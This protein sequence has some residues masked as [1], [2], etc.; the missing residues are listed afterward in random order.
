M[1]DYSLARKAA[2]WGVHAITAF[3]A[4]CGINA[5]LAAMNAEW[6]LFFVWLIVATAIDGID[7]MLARAADVKKILPTFDGALLD[8][9]VDY[10]TYVIAPAVFLYVYGLVPKG[11]GGLA[12]G[13][14]AMASAYQFCQANAK[15]DDH[16]FVG[17]PSYWNIVV[18]YLFLL[19]L[20]PWV[21]MATIAGL[22]LLV[23]VPMK[24]LYPSRTVRFRTLTMVLTIA[25]SG[26]LLY[27]L[28]VYPEPHP[29]AACLS[30]LYVAYYLVASVYVAGGLHLWLYIPPRKL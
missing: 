27:L 28:W 22:S 16:F 29:V 20:N 5:I 14:I 2:A 15:T 17:F 7:G 6:K 11:Y 4:V 24:F 30:L 1:A 18:L 12:A 13:M 23:F 9:I 21:N 25:W 26:L 19:E 3:G 10:L 8:N